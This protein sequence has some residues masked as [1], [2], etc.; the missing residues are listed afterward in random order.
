MV[1]PN[2]LLPYPKTHRGT[3]EQQVI[4]DN[5]AHGAFAQP[6]GYLEFIGRT[7]DATPTEIFLLGK[8]P[9]SNGV[10]GFRSDSAHRLYVPEA[11]FLTADFTF[12]GYDVTTSPIVAGSVRAAGFGSFSVVRPDGGNVA[13]ATAAT[14]TAAAGVTKLTNPAYSVYVGDSAAVPVAVSVDTTNQCVKFTV[15]GVAAKTILWRVH[16][17]P[18][19][20]ISTRA[21]PVYGDSG[22][23]DSLEP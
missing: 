7:T 6:D 18:V 3:I 19:F 13:L 9:I 21:L 16:V 5:L 12:A 1:V 22:L 8:G 20:S 14:G 23:G 17:L 2:Y 11:S 4:T 10:G 15:T